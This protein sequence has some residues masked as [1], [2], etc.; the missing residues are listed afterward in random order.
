MKLSYTPIRD[1]IA[2]YRDFTLVKEEKR[3]AYLLYF[4]CSSDGIPRWLSFV[5]NQISNRQTSLNLKRCLFIPTRIYLVLASITIGITDH[6][7]TTK[8]VVV[9]GLMDMTMNPDCRLVLHD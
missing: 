5:G 2:R 6:P 9:T 7:G 3:N 1:H 8:H 4:N